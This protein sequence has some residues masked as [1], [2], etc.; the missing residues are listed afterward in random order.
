MFSMQFITSSPLK[1]CFEKRRYFFKRVLRIQENYVISET[2]ILKI[3]WTC[4]HSNSSLRYSAHTV[5]Y[6]ILSWGGGGGQGKWALCPTTGE[7]LKN[8][9]NWCKLQKFLQFPLILFP[10]KFLART[11]ISL[12]QGKNLCKW[13]H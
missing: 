2:Q 13:K 5:S 1:L 7:S 4:P 6:H 10:C 9:L 8:A 12:L 3:S 11:N